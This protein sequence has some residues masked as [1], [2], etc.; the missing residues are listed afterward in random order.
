MAQSPL[1]N[2]RSAATPVAGTGAVDITLRLLDTGAVLPV[3]GRDT[4]D[5]VITSL[6]GLT[7][8]GVRDALVGLHG[9]GPAPAWAEMEDA[10]WGVVWNARVWER[11][12]RR[13]GA[14]VPLQ[15][16]VVYA[17]WRFE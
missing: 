6:R 10:E 9:A 2:H 15:E 12:K 11:V 3:R 17:E 1:A 4:L 5:T 7:P 8:P 14:Q 13:G 16:V